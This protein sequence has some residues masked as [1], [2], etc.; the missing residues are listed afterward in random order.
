M[1]QVSYCAGMYFTAVFEDR[2]R[3]GEE[4]EPRLDDED[5][6]V[7]A[8]VMEEAVRGWVSE[9]DSVVP[10][11][12]IFG[13]NSGSGGGWA[14]LGDMEVPRLF[15]VDLIGSIGAAGGEYWVPASA[16]TLVEVVEKLSIGDNGLLWELGLGFGD[17]GMFLGKAAG[18]GGLM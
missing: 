5:D 1:S 2:A 8:N 14:D 11:A 18:G 10:L 4:P 12:G 3:L 9:V 16:V 13:S 6:E 17:C 15:P 7:F